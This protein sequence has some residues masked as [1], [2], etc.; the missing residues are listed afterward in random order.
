MLPSNY[1]ATGGRDKWG[2][3]N[4]SIP[5]Y[6]ENNRQMNT[7]VPVSAPTPAPTSRWQAPGIGGAM[8]IAGNPAYS[9]LNRPS[10]EADTF[11]PSAT[12]LTA[13][14]YTENDM[15]GNYPSTAAAPRPAMPLGRPST[16]ADAFSDP[17]AP[18]VT[19]DAW[20]RGE[21]KPALARLSAQPKAAERWGGFSGELTRP[22]G[23]GALD[24]TE[25]QKL[26]SAESSARQSYDYYARK[27]EKRFRAGGQGGSRRSNFAF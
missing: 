2:T 4:A 6:L 26:D 17:R 18:S 14:Q 27:D 25:Q 11:D 1:D 3:P 8:A 21:L 15:R 22:M 10:T 19:P 12:E 9:R 16:E 24:R 7:M 13:A 5:Q 20:Q 23:Q